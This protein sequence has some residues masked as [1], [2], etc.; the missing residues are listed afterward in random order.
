VAKTAPIPSYVLPLSKARFAFTC[1]LSTTV[2]LGIVQIE[3][4]FAVC[5]H[6]YPTLICRPIAVQ[7][8]A[9]NVIAIFEFAQ[10]AD[11]VGVY[12]EKHYKLV[13]PEDVTDEDRLTYRE[14]SEG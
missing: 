3:Q 4:D 13:P 10:N 9:E 14:K 5:A 7:F 6:R 12:S 2:V 11:G 1:L 8:M